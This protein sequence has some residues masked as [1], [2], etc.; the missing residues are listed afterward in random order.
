MI[1]GPLPLTAGPPC[2]EA[3]RSVAA[4]CLDRSLRAPP[5]QLYL[6]SRIGQPLHPVYWT[7]SLICAFLLSPWFDVFCLLHSRAVCSCSIVI[8]F[9]FSPSIE[10]RD[11]SSPLLPHL[12]SNTPPIQPILYPFAASFLPHTPPTSSLSALATSPST[13]WTT[14]SPMPCHAFRTQP[15]L[16]VHNGSHLIWN[17]EVGVCSQSVSG[18][19][20][21]SF[22]LSLVF[23]GTVIHWRA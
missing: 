5:R 16:G 10:H 22:I 17:P 6:A 7:E 9:F 14:L 1:Q 12:F 2:L 8:S 19:H 21:P 13:Q 20:P 15:R 18:S 11:C 4:T 3:M 23:F